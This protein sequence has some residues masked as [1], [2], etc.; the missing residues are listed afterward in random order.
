VKLRVDP[1]T[2]NAFH[3]TA[4]EGLS[5]AEAA[6]R[7]GLKVATVFVAKSRVQ[8]LLQDE[9]RALEQDDS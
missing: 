7:T 1:P 8:K 2:W 9:V 4:V 3:L 6:E 5:G